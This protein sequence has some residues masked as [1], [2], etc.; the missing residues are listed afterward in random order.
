MYTNSITDAVI[1]PSHTLCKSEEDYEE[2][3]GLILKK[4]VSNSRGDDRARPEVAGLSDPEPIS[5]S[6]LWHIV[7]GEW[8]GLCHVF[9]LCATIL[10][11]LPA[12]HGL[13]KFKRIISTSYSNSKDIPSQDLPSDAN[14]FSPTQQKTS[15]PLYLIL[16]DPLPL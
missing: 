8:K 12:V 16:S 13:P 9:F 15:R 3:N 1:Y 11:L 7:I 10:P 4:Q 2:L 6:K 5:Y 14:I